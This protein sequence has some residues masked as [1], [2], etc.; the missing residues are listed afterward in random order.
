MPS[1][2]LPS[3]DDVI[4]RQW[5]GLPGQLFKA[6]HELLT[7]LSSSR[8]ACWQHSSRA[9]SVLTGAPFDFKAQPAIGGVQACYSTEL[10]RS[11]RRNA[12]HLV[13]A[14]LH[15]KPYLTQ[16]VAVKPT[17]VSLPPHLSLN[18]WPQAAANA[19]TVTGLRL[20]LLQ[21]CPARNVCCSVTTI[22]KARC[23][24]QMLA[25]AIGWYRQTN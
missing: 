2:V 7:S 3:S 23:L 5:A 22:R 6:A 1:C 17:A 13:R 15:N 18:W 21:R 4:Y 20:Q 14:L 9:S 11:S 16:A 19:G 8:T 24:Q 10:P 12:R 25:N